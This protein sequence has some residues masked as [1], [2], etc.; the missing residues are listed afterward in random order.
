M[1]NNKS[2]KSKTMKKFFIG[3]VYG[4]FINQLFEL[5]S[6]EPFQIFPLETDA[7]LTSEELDKLKKIVLKS[8]DSIGTADIV[9]YVS[10]SKKDMELKYL[11]DTI[12]DLTEKEDCEHVT[13]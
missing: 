1:P 8:F 4:K 5:D 13:L 10:L 12:I 2:N 7:V 3:E 6:E 9:P 11:D